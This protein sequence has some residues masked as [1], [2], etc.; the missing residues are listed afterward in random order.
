MTAEELAQLKSTLLGLENGFSIKSAVPVD[1]RFLM[2]KAEMLTV[3]EAKMP[4]VYF[5]LCI[6]DGNLYVY[7][8]DNAV[9]AVTG[10]FRALT[11][12]ANLAQA[13]R[14]VGTINNTADL[15]PTT[16][17]DNF[18]TDKSAVPAIGD[19][20]NLT[21]SFTYNGDTY[22]AGTN[23]IISEVSVD[24]SSLSFSFDPLGGIFDTTE[25]NT[26]ISNA[27]AATGHITDVATTDNIYD[28]FSS[29]SKSGNTLNVTNNYGFTVDE[30]AVDSALT[31]E[32][33]KVAVFGE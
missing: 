18:Y 7:N 27:I 12:I 23:V 6:E 20:L 22:P 19:V 32:K 30:V 26:L 8:K 1:E 9:D 14:Y 13:L 2:T 28:P 16:D 5:T 11:D 17:I 31:D 33:V 10:K 25:I 29:L 3:N 24:G 4:S 21:N 15:D